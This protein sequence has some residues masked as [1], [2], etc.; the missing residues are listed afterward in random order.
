MCIGFGDVIQQRSPDTGITGCTCDA[1]AL[2]TQIKNAHLPRLVC[3]GSAGL[4]KPAYVTSLQSGGALCAD[5][6]T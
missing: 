4:P 2:V 6:F 1:R 5:V 3:A